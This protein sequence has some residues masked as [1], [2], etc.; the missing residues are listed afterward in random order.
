MTT[1]VISRSATLTKIGNSQGI[2]IPRP[3]CKI[4]NIQLGDDVT[5]EVEENGRLTVEPKRSY[6]L[7]ALMAGY[8][9]P[10]PAEYD[11]GAPA[12]KEMW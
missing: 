2:V 11:W 9:G 4:M 1:A 10:K 3:I 12:G 7:E 8:D 6:T 5:L